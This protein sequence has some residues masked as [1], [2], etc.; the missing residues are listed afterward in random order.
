MWGSGALPVSE[1]LLPEANIN[2]DLRQWTVKKLCFLELS[3]ELYV[4]LFQQGQWNLVLEILSFFIVYHS[5]SIT[6]SLILYN[7]AFAWIL[8]VVV[9][10]E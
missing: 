9:A 4:L 5:L 1:A 3:F 10:Y 7:L 6:K 2:L 8:V